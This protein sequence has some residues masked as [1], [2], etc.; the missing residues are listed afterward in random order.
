MICYIAGKFK[1][2]N[3]KKKPRCNGSRRST[4]AGNNSLLPSDN[5]DFCND[6][7][8]E[9]LAGNSFIVRCYVTSR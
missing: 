1:A 6:S 3:S 4:F 5:I 9:I 2:G 8:S 7:L